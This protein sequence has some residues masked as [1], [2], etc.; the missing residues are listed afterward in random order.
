MPS[1]VVEFAARDPER[2]GRWWADALGWTVVTGEHVVV[3]PVGPG[4]PLRFISTTRTKTGKN[5]VHLDL[6]SESHEEQ[7]KTV[8]R[9][10]NAGA[11]FADIEQGNEVPWVVMADPEGN[12]F[13]V[14][15]P[16]RVY[17]DTGPLAAVVVDC[18]D[19]PEEGHAWA[20]ATG[21]SLAG[22][23]PEYVGLRPAS[24]RGPHLEFLKSRVADQGM[25][26][27]TTGSE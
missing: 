27:L 6:R 25:L 15:E 8:E 5:S 3:R 1:V 10:F 7:N 11:R 12:E 16:R 21:M 2:L 23:R 22:E 17:A 19:P 13:C 14:L 9:L 24:G 18:L 26:R 20:G 4:I